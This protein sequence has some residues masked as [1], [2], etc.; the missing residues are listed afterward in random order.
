MTIDAPRRTVPLHRLR[1]LGLVGPLVFVC[2]LLT[3]R[4]WVL[5]TLGQEAGQRTLGIV[6]L[7][8]SVAFGWLM[9]RL[10]GRAHDAVVEAERAA[11][12]LIER[13]RI[14]REMH[15]SLAQVL[16]V[17]HLRLRAVQAR[18]TIAQDERCHADIDDLANLCRDA[19]RDVREAIVG[20]KDAHHPERTLLE[21]LEGFVATFSRTSGIPTTLYADV[22][23]DLG[24][25][26]A[27]QVQVIRV[28]QEALTNA[29]KH[30][31]AS[32]ASVRVS[33]RS[34]HTEFV[35]E[36]DG[37]GFDPTGPRQ[38][39]F[40][41]CTMRERTESVGGSLHIE[42]APGRGTRVVVRLPGGHGSQ[43]TASVPVGEL[44]A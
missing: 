27:A 8:S 30:A 6:L 41:L 11:G 4:P 28:V 31:G 25:S 44:S 5:A 9:F 21:H 3:R 17:A 23:A 2:T 43:P 16:G 29:R 34:T 32:A 26:E 42:S 22:D 39:G 20:L 15:D 38:Q 13:D 36:D 19:H 33:A 7:T 40:G 35:V 37:A 10:L 12:A 14:A 18:P 1:L 24:L